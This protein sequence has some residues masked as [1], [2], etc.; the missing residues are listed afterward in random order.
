MNHNQLLS[1]RVNNK[2]LGENVDVAPLIPVLLADN[3]IREVRVSVLCFCFFLGGGVNYD[4]Y[5]TLS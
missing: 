4:A 1:L 3:V 5:K 2:L